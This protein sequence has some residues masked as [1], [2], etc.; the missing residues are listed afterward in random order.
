MGLPG[1]GKS[2]WAEEV[3]NDSRNSDTYIIHLD[4][5]REKYCFWGN[6]YAARDYIITG[7]GDWR[8]QPHVVLDGLFLTNDDLFQAITCFDGYTG[9]KINVIV[10]RWDEDRETCL[11]NDGGRRETKSTGTILNAP[12]EDVD[13]NLLNNR[14][15]RYGMHHVEVAQVIRHKVTLKPDWIRY[16]KS[17]VDFCDDGKLRSERWS[18]GGC[19]GNCWDSSMR[20]SEG[21]EPL[22]FAALDDLLDAKCPDLRYRHYRQ[23]RQE[24]VSTEE[25]F[26]REYYGGCTNYMNWVCDLKKMYNLL[27]ELGYVI[28]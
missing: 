24:C 12:Y 28:D 16:Y 22:D 1:S 13:I 17:C 9:S 4:E 5:I 27:I 20:Y 6:G 25:T 26:E 11:K 23:I 21:D 7:M 2:S 15:T 14:L 3:R 10:H 19:Y 18:I 8:R